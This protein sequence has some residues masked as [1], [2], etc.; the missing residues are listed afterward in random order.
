M[1]E[2]NA[3]ILYV[4]DEASIRMVGQFALEEVGQLV[5]EPCSSGQ[6]A[7]ARAAGFK[8]DV[9][10]LD[11]MMPGMDG[12]ATFKALKERPDMAPVPVI[13]MTAKVQP[14]EVEG[15]RKLGAVAVIAKPFDPL[16]LS[17]EVK[18]ILK[19]SRGGLARV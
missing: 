5:V 16:T 14:Q 11:V 17:D 13:F 8:P 4:E 1:N 15:Y 6:E 7:L 10:L 18:A 19:R 2:T 9:V 3:R 12:V